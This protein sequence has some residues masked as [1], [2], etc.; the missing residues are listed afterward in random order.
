MIPPTS[1]GVL[2]DPRLPSGSLLFRLVPQIQQIHGERGAAE[3]SLPADPSAV[4]ERALALAQAGADRLRSDYLGSE[5]IVLGLLRLPACRA[6]S[7][8]ARHG[9][10]LE[11]AR[12][13][14][15]RG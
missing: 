1:W 7:V 4:L 15:S 6:A 13:A 10:T 11:V 5:H 3:Q 2:L 9:V 8:L 12:A 14:L